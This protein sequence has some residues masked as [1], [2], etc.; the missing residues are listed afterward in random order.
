MTAYHT[1]TPPAKTAPRPE[2]AE[3]VNTMLI[4]A[5]YKLYGPEW[6]APP[7]VHFSLSTG[8]VKN[9]VR[10]ILHS[11]VYTYIA[12]R[13]YFCDRRY[14]R[15][16][17]R[18]YAWCATLLTPFRTQNMERAQHILEFESQLRREADAWARTCVTATIVD[19]L[20]DTTE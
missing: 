7:L 11:S 2:L 13:V 4:A 8:H 6:R 20:K 17:I 12:D 15:V 10:C 9:E 1:A 3:E 19:S 14:P 5:G 16:M 18:L